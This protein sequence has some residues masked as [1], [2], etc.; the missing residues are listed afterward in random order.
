MGKQEC[1]NIK[2]VKYNLN[3]FKG[4]WYEI[5]RSETLL[6]EVSHCHVKEFTEFGLEGGL[7]LKASEQQINTEKLTFGKRSD[8][9][10]R[11]RTRNATSSGPKQFKTQF[12]YKPD[13]T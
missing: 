11:I 6:E 1:A 5:W 9:I 3:D 10:G 2:A 4:V 7:K 13:F 8:Q 12:E